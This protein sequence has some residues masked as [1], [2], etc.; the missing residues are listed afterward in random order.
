MSQASGFRKSYFW[1]DGDQLWCDPPGVELVSAPRKSDGPANADEPGVNYNF[2]SEQG[3]R[4][5]ARRIPLCQSSMYYPLK[6]RSVPHFAVLRSI[7]GGV[8]SSAIALLRDSK[9]SE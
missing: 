4:R 5:G 1:S 8:I 9:P 2:I 7:F 3:L 6:S